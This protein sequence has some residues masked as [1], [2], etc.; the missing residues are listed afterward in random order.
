V[1]TAII[2]VSHA[3]FLSSWCSS[4]LS[5]TEEDASVEYDLFA[6][7]GWILDNSSSMDLQ[8][9]TVLELHM[10]RNIMPSASYAHNRTSLLVK[11]IANLHCH[12]PGRCE[13]WF[14][15]NAC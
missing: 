14:L 12:V 11:I 9:P 13:G 2:S 8:N 3:D 7:V 10:I 5:E 15:A 1:L 4:N 6:T